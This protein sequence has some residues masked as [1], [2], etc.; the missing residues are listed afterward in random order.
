MF[1]MEFEPP[2]PVFEQLHR[3][4]T[5]IFCELSLFNIIL[6]QWDICI[7]AYININMTCPLVHNSV[8][9]TCLNTYSS[10]KNICNADV[11]SKPFCDK[12]QSPK[13]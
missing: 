13:G 10:L 7:Y 4:Y 12:N 6:F 9:L 1:G 5:V 8:A 2:V 3:A 11:L